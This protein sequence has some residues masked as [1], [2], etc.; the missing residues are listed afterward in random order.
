MCLEADRAPAVFACR[1]HQVL[2]L[3]I[4]SAQP[5]VNVPRPALHWRYEPGP[6]HAFRFRL[7]RS[8]PSH[9][10]VAELLRLLHILLEIHTM[11]VAKVNFPANQLQSIRCSDREHKQQQHLK[12]E[13]I[14][15]I[16]IVYKYLLN[17]LKVNRGR[18]R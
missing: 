13:S 7:C 2:E 8:S 18:L 5:T 11:T 9:N 1:H 17:M 14:I 3:P 12:K 10:E 15:I 6:V 4:W 16:I